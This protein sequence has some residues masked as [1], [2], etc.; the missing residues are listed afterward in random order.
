MDEVTEFRIPEENIREYLGEQVTIS[1]NKKVGVIKAKKGSNL[2][3]KIIDLQKLFYS[4]S[5]SFFFGW[6]IVRNYSK[7]EVEKA[8]YFLGKIEKVI[9]CCGQEGGTNYNDSN[10]CFFCGGG[11]KQ[12]SD[13]ILDRSKL[14]KS[15]KV[16]IWKTFAGEIGISEKF[17]DI[18]LMNGYPSDGIGL[19][20]K[21]NGPGNVVP[22]WFQLKIETFF[23]K[24][25]AKTEAGTNPFKIDNDVINSNEKILSALEIAASKSDKLGI[26]LCPFGHTIGL[27]LLSE[28]F[29]NKSHGD[30]LISWTKECIGV[31]RGFLR[32]EHCLIFNSAFYRLKEKYKLT[33]LKFEIAHLVKE[34][35]SEC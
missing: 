35:N 21:G 6:D 15:D 3:K 11:G 13:L 20:R 16:D 27:N 12:T 22:G 10:A 24:I 7:D 33:G 26:Y 5:K 34:K 1:T 32:P 28:I 2:Y 25:A 31:R 19:I 30:F 4:N 8:E 23:Y 9:G 14:P 29:L 18:L 17:A